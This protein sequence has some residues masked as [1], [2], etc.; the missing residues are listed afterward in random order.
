MPA[1][2][3]AWSKLFTR[4]CQALLQVEG[5]RE[6]R[7]QSGISS[8][9]LPVLKI[10]VSSPDEYQTR[11]SVRKPVSRSKMIRAGPDKNLCFNCGQVIPSKPG[12]KT[13]NQRPITQLTTEGTP[14]AQE[15]RNVINEITL[16]PPKISSSQP[17]QKQLITF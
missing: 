1:E 8:S 14:T 12:S 13:N 16:S 15:S 2:I 4:K 6:Q 3:V 11:I 5:H 7:R 17:Q 10:G 9:Y